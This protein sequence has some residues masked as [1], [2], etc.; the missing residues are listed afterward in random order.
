M[1]ISFMLP[2]RLVLASITLPVLSHIVQSLMGA[3][4]KKES[5]DVLVNVIFVAASRL[6]AVKSIGT[7]TVNDPGA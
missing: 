3:S 1:L 4:I 6:G 7:E 2:K 5:R